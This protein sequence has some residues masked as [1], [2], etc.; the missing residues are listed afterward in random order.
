[1]YIVV[2]F[3]IWILFSQIYMLNKFKFT[4][5]M[6]PS[7]KTLLYNMK[8]MITILKLNTCTNLSL[9]YKLTEISLSTI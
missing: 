1:M 2:R 5:I 3:F 6:F 8:I 9:K 4:K 7:I